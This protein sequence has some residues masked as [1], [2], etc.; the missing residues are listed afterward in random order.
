MQLA[1][2]DGLRASGTFLVGEHHQGAPG[3]AHGGVLAVALDEILGA[4]NWLLAGPAVTGQIEVAYRR[5]VPVGTVLYLDA[6]V[7]GVKGRKVFTSAQGRLNSEAGDV[8]VTAT[9][10]FVQVPVEHF[11]QNGAAEHVQ[12][13]MAD[14]AAGG[15]AWRPG[16][17][18]TTVEVNP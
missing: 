9:A 3:L 8:A 7:L 6:E 17:E 18:D 15:P 10:L 1:A 5:P 16:G 14:R 13:A 4:L 2:G 11:L 12:Q